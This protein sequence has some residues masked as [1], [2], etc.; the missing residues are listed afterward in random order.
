MAGSRLGWAVVRSVRHLTLVSATIWLLTM[1][2][3]MA[4]FHLCTPIAVIVNSVVW[5]PMAWGLISGARPA[6][7]GLDCAAAGACVRLT[8]AT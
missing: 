7:R 8:A 6:G 4:R 1:P 2:L 5:M 3:V